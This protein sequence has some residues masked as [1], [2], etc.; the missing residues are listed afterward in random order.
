MHQGS[1]KLGSSFRN[2]IKRA[3]EMDPYKF[4]YRSHDKTQVSVPSNTEKSNFDTHM[5]VVTSDS[6]QMRVEHIDNLF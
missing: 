5:P 3:E 2:R 6:V 4:L 1:I